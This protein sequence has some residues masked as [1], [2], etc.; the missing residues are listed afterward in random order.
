MNARWL[1]IR[2]SSFAAFLFVAGCQVD[3]SVND[4]ARAEAPDEVPGPT[5][6]VAEAPA[7]PPVE[8]VPPNQAM[9]NLSRLEALPPA[10]Q[11]AFRRRHRDGAGVTHVDIQQLE[12]GPNAYRVSYIDDAGAPGVDVYHEDGRAIEPGA[13]RPADWTF[14]VSTRG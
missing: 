9:Y 11:R 1:V 10:V 6:M 2:A 13:R 4:S 8:G 5:T 14:W 12:T 7:V 3:Q